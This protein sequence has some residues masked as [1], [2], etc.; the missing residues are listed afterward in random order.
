MPPPDFLGIHH[1]KFAVSEL[2]RSLAFYSRALGA[3]RLSKLDHIDAAGQLFAIILE[4]PNLGAA[5]ELR[6]SA[7]HAAKQ[8]GFDPITLTVDRLADLQ[9]WME[10]FD[11]EGVPH[12]PILTGYVGWLLVFEDPDGRRIRFYTNQRHGPEVTSSTDA[13]WL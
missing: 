3:R 4:V 1:L 7:E 6:L 5:L 10:H 9:K 8:K 13:R 2:D 11:T 12:S